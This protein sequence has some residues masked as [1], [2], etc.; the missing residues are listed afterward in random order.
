MRTVLVSY[1]APALGAAMSR[2][3]TDAGYEVLV[4]P[5]SAAMAA[6]RSH[7]AVDVLVTDD[8]RLLQGPHDLTGR[9]RIEQPRLKVF[10]APGVGGPI[11]PD[12]R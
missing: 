7:G 1:D 12:S 8:G 10:Y 4:A 9:Q 6:A 11:E 2:L 5:P 3:L